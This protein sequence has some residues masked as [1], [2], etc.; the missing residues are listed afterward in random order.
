MP[1]PVSREA[2]SARICCVRHCNDRGLDDKAR[3]A[4]HELLYIAEHGKQSP[5]CHNYDEWTHIVLLSEV[6]FK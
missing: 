4:V 6:S 3:C 1:S 2:F 5:T